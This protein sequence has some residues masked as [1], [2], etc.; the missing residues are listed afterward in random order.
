[1]EMTEV[2]Y[3]EIS[4]RSP[5]E[6]S[7]AIRARTN[8]ARERQ[9]A[10]YQ[11]TDIKFNAQ[12]SGRQIDRFCPLDQRAQALMERA[13]NSMNLSAR[14]YGRIR[15]VARTIADLEGAETIGP[16]H[17]SEALQYRSLDKKYWGG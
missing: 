6:P 13:F 12:L 15:K 3:E 7:S 4:S 14:A 10:R 17:I 9:R 1:M 11:G 5:G 2:Y 16:Q 8:Q